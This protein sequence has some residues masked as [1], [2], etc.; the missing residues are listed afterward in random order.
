MAFN[1]A[2]LY[3]RAYCA[4]LRT[5]FVPERSHRMKATEGPSTFCAIL[6]GKT[7]NKKT[8]P[9]GRPARPPE[10]ADRTGE[11]ST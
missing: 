1:A 8:D 4:P 7:K 3:S 6:W 5:L 10:G 9:L 11:H 2:K